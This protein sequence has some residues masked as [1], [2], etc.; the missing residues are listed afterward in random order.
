MG[1]RQ[2]DELL[3]VH[4]LADIAR[5][6]RDLNEMRLLIHFVQ[7]QQ[8]SCCCRSLIGRSTFCTCL[9][10]Q[11]FLKV[12]VLEHPRKLLPHHPSCQPLQLTRAQSRDKSA[13]PRVCV[14]EHVQND[15]RVDH[16]ARGLVH[17]P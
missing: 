14:Q 3:I 5:T 16:H 15:V 10:H 9:S 13:H 17:K 8:S 11:S 12:L 7:D 2:V 4:I 6:W 1:L